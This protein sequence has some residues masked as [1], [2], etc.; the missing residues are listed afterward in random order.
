M[1]WIKRKKKRKCLLCYVGK[2][3]FY[4]KRIVEL[5]ILYFLKKN[6]FKNKIRFLKNERN[7]KC[8][9]KEWKKLM[10]Y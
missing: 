10:D 9:F 7:K 5:Y 1:N 4:L 6:V 3:V 2:L 8:N